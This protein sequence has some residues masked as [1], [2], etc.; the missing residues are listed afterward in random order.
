MDIGAIL[1][2]MA[3]LVLTVPVVARPFWKDQ[4]M[5]TGSDHHKGRDSLNGRGLKP[6]YDQVLAALRDLDF[7]YQTGKI[8][9]QDYTVLRSEL[10]VQAAQIIQSRETDDEAIEKLIQARRETLSKVAALRCSRCGRKLSV[11]D[12]FCSGCGEPIAVTCSKCGQAI[13]SED[14]FCSAC[15]VAIAVES[16]I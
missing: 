10:V 8:V 11:S 13:T 12:R 1:I 9:E 5:R 4:T 7:D 16:E 15:G 14:K 2:G 3:L 6:Q